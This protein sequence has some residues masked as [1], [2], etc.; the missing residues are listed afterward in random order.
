VHCF[1]E[2]L[3]KQI[4]LFALLLVPPTAPAASPA[5]VPEFASRH[6]KPAAQDGEEITP[7]A[8]ESIEKGLDWLARNQSSSSGAYGSGSA[9]VATTAIA[10]L[11]FLAGGH[12]PR[13]SKYGEKVL[14]AVRFL[15]RMANKTSGY[16]N[17]GQARGI[18]VGPE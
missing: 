18:G 6:D 16:I 12:L 8:R 10:G 5:P 1:A 17:E 13:R 4:A 2:F 14:K 11:A 7:K 9:P 15:L 3:L